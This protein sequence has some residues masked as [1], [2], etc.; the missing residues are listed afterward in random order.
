MLD[1]LVLCDGREKNMSEQLTRAKGIEGGRL[2]AIERPRDVV[3]KP[4]NY[5]IGFE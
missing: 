5:S 2:G 1:S 3:E 4:L